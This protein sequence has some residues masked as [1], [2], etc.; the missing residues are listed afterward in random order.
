MCPTDTT[1]IENTAA[2]TGVVKMAEN[3]PL[4]PHIIIVPMLSFLSF[5]SLPAAEPIPPP[6]CS[7]A[8]SLP[9]EP[10]KRCVKNAPINIKG[11]SRFDAA[12]F[13]LMQSIT[14]FV[15]RFCFERRY[16]AIMTI[17]AS[18][19]KNIRR[20]FPSLVCVAKAIAL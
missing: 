4:I 14:V 5:K 18:G 16:I 2:V 6:I 20:G 15:E 19:R 7:A 12:C 11:T 3:A 1:S 17:P 13:D 10:P 8:P 9:A